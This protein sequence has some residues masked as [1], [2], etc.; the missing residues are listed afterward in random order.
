MK[1]IS[2]ELFN[3]MIFRGNQKIDFPQDD[4][5]NILLIFGENMHGK[6]TLQ[7]AIRWAMYGEAVD[8][9]KKLIPDDQLLNIDAKENNEKSLSVKLKLIADG[10]SYEIFRSAEIDRSGSNFSL[11]LKEDG[12]V[13]DGGI[14]QPKIESLVSKQIS[15]FLLFDGELLNEFELLVVDEGSSQAKAIKSSIEK[16]L[17]LPVLRRAV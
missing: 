2:L 13:Q 5:A 14:S 11:I 9:Q 6:S 10:K 1:F 8:R 15:Q 3:W 17:G 16:A 7:N 4:R 12:R